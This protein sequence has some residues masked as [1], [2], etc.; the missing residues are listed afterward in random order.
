MI[1]DRYALRTKML[2]RRDA[3]LPGVRAS[4]S[5]RILAH[6][7]AWEGFT[8]AS[9][10]ALYMPMRG[11]VDVTPL[12]DTPGKTILLP[13]V[14]VDGGM[15]FS[16]Y[17]GKE[18]MV[19]HRYGMLEPQSTQWEPSSSIDLLLVPGVA[20]DATGG[21]MGYGAGFYDRYLTRVRPDTIKLGVAYRAQLVDELPLSAHDVLMDQLITEDGLVK[22]QKKGSDLARP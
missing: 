17:T 9:V 15:E 1:K 7:C 10:I 13:T 5:K 2:A 16:L 12:L 4:L 11:E 22:L 18:E 8:N 14:Q 20:F 21:R 6:I 3:L 19:R